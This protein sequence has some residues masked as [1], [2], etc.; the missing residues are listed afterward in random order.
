[1]LN[2]AG[3]KYSRYFRKLYLTRKD[4]KWHGD[5]SSTIEKEQ[6]L[7]KENATQKLFKFLVLSSKEFIDKIFLLIGEFSNVHSSLT[8]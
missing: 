3:K 8:T 7:N 6:F 2:F 4:K 1:M 5:L